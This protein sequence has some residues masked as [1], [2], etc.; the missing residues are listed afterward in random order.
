MGLLTHRCFTTTSILTD[1]MTDNCPQCG[2]NLGLVGRAHN[3]VVNI[4][5]TVNTAVNRG[6]YPNTDKRRAYMRDYMRKKRNAQN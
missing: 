3:C 6:E 4:P 5:P 1:T 2:K